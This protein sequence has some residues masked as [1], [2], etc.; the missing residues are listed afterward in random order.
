MC[1]IVEE[2]FGDEGG[3]HVMTADQVDTEEETC[4]KCKTEK[5]V[6][7]SMCHNCFLNYV[8][9]KFR[10]SLGCTKIV[11][12]GSNVLLHFSGSAANVCLTEMIRFAFEQESHKRLSFDLELVYIDE[13]CV[14]KEG[15]DDP[16]FRL[17]K[18]C[19]VK[20]VLEQFPNFKCHYTSIAGTSDVEFVLVDDMKL[21]DVENVIASETKFLKK[22]NALKSL[23]SQQD[24][25]EVTRNDLLRH[26]ATFLECQYVFL[27]DISTTLADRF[28]TNMVRARLVFICD[29]LSL[30]I[31][32]SLLVSRSRKLSRI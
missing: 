18:L 5:S 19:N 21:K 24:L 27:S 23:S 16:E 10:G 13:N 26:A 25:L 20:A 15:Q 1:S 4:K 2:D 8:R 31:S 6:I 28:I 17:K 11:R 29:A 9:H 7:K 30:I 32:S 3:A 22:F 12:R 14:L